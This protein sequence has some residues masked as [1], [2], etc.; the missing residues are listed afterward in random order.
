[1]GSLNLS[2]ISQVIFSDQTEK[3]DDSV[4]CDYTNPFFPGFMP[5]WMLTLGR[6]VIRDN[7]IIIP[8]QNM[9]ISLMYVVVP[10][11]LGIL[12]N[13][14]MDHFKKTK[15]KMMMIRTLRVFCVISI[16]FAITVGKILIYE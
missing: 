16:I 9:V 3:K 7:N 10:V 4:L 8:F 2:V 12:V 13:K 11:F 15:A 14:L 6:L 5:L 1:M